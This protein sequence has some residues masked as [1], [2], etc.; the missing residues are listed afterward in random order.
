MLSVSS[1]AVPVN[2]QPFAAPVNTSAPPLAFTWLFCTPDT[3]MPLAVRLTPVISKVSVPVVPVRD[4]PE[5]SAPVTPVNVNILSVNSFR[6]LVNNQPEV[7]PLNTSAPPPAL[8]V[9]VEPVILM[10]L[11]SS[12]PPVTL[13]VSALSEPVRA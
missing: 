1:F 10:L 2:D 9:L 8:I 3:A 11:A 13:N 6:L 5:R 7:V 4:S 12:V